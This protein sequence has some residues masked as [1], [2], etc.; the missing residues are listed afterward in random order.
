MELR[1]DIVKQKRLAKNWTQQQLAD[2]C[3]INLRTIQRVEKS[4]NASLE[5]IMS[6]CVAFDVKREVFFEVPKPTNLEDNFRL[7]KQKSHWLIAIF[8]AGLAS[9]VAFSAMMLRFVG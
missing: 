2:I 4:G 9:G 3:D 6:L 7:A 5:T 1:G 8:V